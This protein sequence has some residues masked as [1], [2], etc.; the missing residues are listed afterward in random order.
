MIRLIERNVERIE[1]LALSLMWNG[2]KV[3][4]ENTKDANGNL[5]TTVCAERITEPLVETKMDSTPCCTGDCAH[6][7]TYENVK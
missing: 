2:H 5:T 1:Q 3:W 7:M 6:K 4:Y